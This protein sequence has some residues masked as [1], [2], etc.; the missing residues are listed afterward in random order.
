[1]AAKILSIP[2]MYPSDTKQIITEIFNLS[3][4]RSRHVIIVSSD[5]TMMDEWCHTFSAG[6]GAKVIQAVVSYRGPEQPS[7]LNSTKQI[8]PNMLQNKCILMITTIDG[9]F[10]YDASMRLA[11]ALKASLYY[12]IGYDKVMATNHLRSLF[13]TYPNHIAP[14]LGVYSNA[15]QRLIHSDET[16]NPYMLATLEYSQFLR[17]MTTA[18]LIEARKH[19]YERKDKDAIPKLYVVG[20]NPQFVSMSLHNGAMV[21]FIERSELGRNLILPEISKKIATSAVDNM[22]N[23]NPAIWVSS[24]PQLKLAQI[25]YMMLNI[26]SQILYLGIHPAQHLYPLKLNGWNIAGVDPSLTPAAISELERMCTN[27]KQFVREFK[28]T[29]DDFMNICVICGF[30]MLKPIVII[31]DTWAEVKGMSYQDF[32]VR[33]LDFYSE[34]LNEERI[35]VTA[36]LKMNL[37]KDIVIPKLLALLP[38]PMGGSLNELRAIMSTSVKSD[39]RYEA[40]KVQLY[41]DEF[42]ALGVKNQI[43]FIEDMHSILVENMD[44][45]DFSFQ[46]GDC[47]SGMFSISNSY[48]QK[49]KV[50]RWMRMMNER[51][52]FAVIS[53]PN[54]ARYLYARRMNFNLGLDIVIKKNRLVF[55]TENKK[56]PWNDSVYTMTELRQNGFITVTA[57]QMAGWLGVKYAGPGYYSH[58]TLCDLMDIAVPEWLAKR[59]FA[60]QHIGTSP[61]GLIKAYTHML[62][63]KRSIPRNQY[64]F[65]RATLLDSYLKREGIPHDSYVISGTER[66][67]LQ[68]LEQV[69]LSTEFGDVFIESGTSINVSGHLLSMTIA[70]HFVPT[71]IHVWIRQ[72]L[73][74]TV[75]T[76]LIEI[77]ESVKDSTLLFDNRIHDGE[78]LP[79]H[80]LNELILTL[81]ILESYVDFMMGGYHSTDIISDIANAFIVELKDGL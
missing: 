17:S 37:K 63:D 47:V 55:K 11:S 75:N 5:A 28:Y 4:N 45:L 65:K 59:I 73:R 36:A 35:N 44:A 6:N 79:W 46:P 66:E 13:E 64:Y 30:D 72:L 67:T 7:L 18:F 41:L 33:K 19:T 40:K 54:K 10:S 48:N 58:S 70:A 21:R 81:C 78:L 26:S 23:K 2:R 76:K 49:T 32:Q 51:R 62:I 31:D 15:V 61:I 9:A 57:E 71:A 12:M 3:L 77:K 27:F 43:K 8:A 39:Y 74:M 20:Y 69:S 24:N 56:H 60:Y 68:F 53:V 42:K 29:M 22:A 14:T 34:L 52:C 38:Q 80:S 25:D 50:L 16:T 1:M